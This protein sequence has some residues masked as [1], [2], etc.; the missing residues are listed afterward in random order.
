[1]VV[2]DQH[3]SAQGLLV[4]QDDT[5]EIYSINRSAHWQSSF[6]LTWFPQNIFLRNVQNIYCG[7]IHFFKLMALHWDLIMGDEWEN[8]LFEIS[9]LWLFIMFVLFI[10]PVNFYTQKAVSRNN[11]PLYSAFQAVSKGNK[12][13]KTIASQQ[14]QTR[15]RKCTTTDSNSSC[16]EIN[17]EWSLEK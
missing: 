12:E 3:T 8:C 4:Q 7:R 15:Q 13:I 11:I 9:E 17:Q 1:M 10:H 6:I 2:E 14:K 16:Y 5:S